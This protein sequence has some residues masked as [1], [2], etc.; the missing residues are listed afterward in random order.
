MAVSLRQV[1][2]VCVRCSP[3]AVCSF[4]LSQIYRLDGQPLTGLER[5]CTGIVIILPSYESMCSMCDTVTVAAVLVSSESDMGWVAIDE[6]GQRRRRGVSGIIY[7]GCTGI[8]WCTAVVA[9]LPALCATT[10]QAEMTGVASSTMDDRRM[11]AG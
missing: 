2:R 9:H 5:D 1:A 4:G 11:F 7:R 8:S 10:P 6:Y 3:L